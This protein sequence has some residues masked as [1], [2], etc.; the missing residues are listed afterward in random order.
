VKDAGVRRVTGDVYADDT[1][2][3]RLRGVPDSGWST[4]PYIGPLAGLTYN[5]GTA[6][7]GFASDPALVAAANLRSDLKRRG[8]RVG[9]KARV[10]KAPQPRRGEEPLAAVESPELSELIEETNHTSNNFFAEMLLK[11][12]AAAGGKAGTTQRGARGVRR[13]AR[14]LGAKVR[15]ADGSGLTRSNRAAPNAVGRLLTA[16]LDHRDAGAFYDSL[17]VAGREGTVAERMRGSAAEGRCRAKTG[18]LH[19]VSA[20][21]GYCRRRTG[22]VVFSI[23]MN[24]VSPTAARALQD[25]MAAAI[26]RYRPG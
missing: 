6:G 13:I 18:T 25:K 24:S 16:M 9:G 11:R 22:T 7:S 26:A 21:S 15:P 20:L 19:D 1:I 3:D 2:F 14:R 4:S 5:S 10:G 8:I 23:L 12:L 17:P